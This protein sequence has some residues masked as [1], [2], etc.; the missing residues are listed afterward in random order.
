MKKIIL[1]I[2]LAIGSLFTMASPDI[3]VPELLSPAN[4]LTGVAPKIDL[5]WNPVVGAA[6]LY[7]QV[8]LSTDEAFTSPSQ[9]TT[10]LTRY[11]VSN[12]MFGGV[13]FWRVK[14]VD[15]LG[16]SDWSE[17]RKFTV[18]VKPVISRPLNNATVDCN[19]ELQWP[20]LNGIDI[21]E[22]QFDTVDTFDSPALALFTAA[23]NLGKGNAS[24]LLFGQKYFMRLRARH[25]ADVSTWSDSRSVTIINTFPLRQ[26]ADGAVGMVPDVELQWTEIKGVNKYIIYIS[27]DPEFTHFEIYNALKTQTR[28]R[29][30]TMNFDTK[31][32]WKMAAIHS[33]DTLYSPVR[34]Y[35]TLPT[36][37]LV[38]PANNSTNVILQ[39]SLTWT[40]ISGVLSY[41]LELGRNSDMTA[42]FRYSIPAAAGTGPASFKVPIHVL[43]SAD[44]FYW[45]VQANSSRDTSSWSQTWNFRTVTLGI[46]EPGSV[47]NDLRVYPVPAINSINI[48]LGNNI[49]GEAEIN[50]YDLLGKV[51]LTAKVPVSS[52]VIR[53]FGLGDLPD[54]MYVLR[55]QLDDIN[56]MSRIV[57]RR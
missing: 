55:L 4:N 37:T 36:V 33:R 23:G 13:Y 12:L 19:V 10:D 8:Q 14:A 9:Y 7:Y 41:S 27:T 46:N 1:L 21:F 40:R 5:D 6:G 53:N 51:R 22:F 39:P 50:L 47:Q 44:V 42:A 2:V 48:K 11:Q 54:G 24:N 29:P 16:S 52:G 35:T 57:I 20:S 3:F 30:D 31:Y 49:N 17:I 34:N 18:I 26:P 56:A 25:S 43:D 32:Y 15:P 38:S 45:R 28:V